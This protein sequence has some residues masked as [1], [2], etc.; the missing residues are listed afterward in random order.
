M[1]IGLR[2]TVENTKKV[3]YEVYILDFEGN[4]YNK[5]IHAEL[6]TYMREEKKFESKEELIEQMKNDVIIARK[7]LEEKYEH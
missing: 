5:H 4:L 2:P 6:L 7:L 3:K 1:N